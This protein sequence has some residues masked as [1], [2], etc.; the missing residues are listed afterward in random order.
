MT[1]LNSDQDLHAPL[2][3]INITPLVDV[4]LV[5]LIIL[6]LCVSA[7]HSAIPLDLPK[8][9]AMAMQ[10]QEFVTISVNVAGEYFLEEKIFTLAELESHLSNISAQN[11][12]QQI[13]LK[14]DA[15]TNYA[16]ITALLTALQ[17]QGLSNITFVT[18]P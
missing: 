10:N 18:Q 8:D 5:L 6:L 12:Q 17:R 9:K 2:T 13:H 16:N 14:A 7:I 11:K 1:M 3:E 15:K 4:L